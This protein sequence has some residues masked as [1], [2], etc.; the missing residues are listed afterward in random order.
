MMK[1][2][3]TILLVVLV[4]VSG[5]AEQGGIAGNKGLIGAGAGAATGAVAGQAIGKN[6]ESTMIGVA[7]GAVAGYI[8]GNEWD[9]YDAS[10]LNKI[11]TTKSG[12]TIAWSNPDNGNQ[13]KVTP[14]PV[15]YG[16]QGTCRP[17]TM[18]ATID[19]RTETVHTKSCRQ[20]NGTWKLKA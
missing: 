15:I 6:T 2:Y 8:A 5:C 11:E 1:I 18:T 13:Y 20:P 17:T 3:S 9:K 7:L 19:G 12:D 16:D 14:Q 10:M 4:V